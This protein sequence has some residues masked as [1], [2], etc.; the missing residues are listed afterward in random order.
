MMWTNIEKNSAVLEEGYVLSAYGFFRVVSLASMQIKSFEIPFPKQ[1]PGLKL[2]KYI[3]P[4]AWPAGSVVRIKKKR[5]KGKIVL[6]KEIEQKKKETE[7]SVAGSRTGFIYTC[8]QLLDHCTTV[9]HWFEKLILSFQNNFSLPLTLFEPCV[10]VFIINSNIH[11]R[12]I[13][14]S[15]Y[16][17]A[18][19]HYFGFNG[20]T[21]CR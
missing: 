12:K 21:Q 16:F 3:D 10:T 1:N 14:L 8:K 15:A 11:L 7:N 6:K 19:S 9:T 2:K 4:S 20:P 13:S 17:K 18:I 5:P